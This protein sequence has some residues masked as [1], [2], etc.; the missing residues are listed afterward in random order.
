[1]YG[2]KEYCGSCGAPW[3]DRNNNG[4][5]CAAPGLMSSEFCVSCMGSGE[6][7]DEM[8]RKVSCADCGGTGEAPELAV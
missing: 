8:F 7:L 2:I 4:F 5:C 6:K 3:I 1:M